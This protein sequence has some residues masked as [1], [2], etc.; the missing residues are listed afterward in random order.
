M[1]RN[2]I[3]FEYC[4]LK[5]IINNY[6]HDKFNSYVWSDIFQLKTVYPNCIIMNYLRNVQIIHNCS[7]D[8]PPT[9]FS[10]THHVLTFSF[11]VY[12]PI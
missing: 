3:R 8:S 1:E 2:K 7:L 9:G 4:L 11:L 12:I 5:N 6:S 10:S